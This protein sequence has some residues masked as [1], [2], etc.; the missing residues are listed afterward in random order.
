MPDSISGGIR[1][2]IVLTA[3][4]ALIYSFLYRSFKKVTD[5]NRHKNTTI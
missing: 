5:N 2:G 4:G 3:A 1:V